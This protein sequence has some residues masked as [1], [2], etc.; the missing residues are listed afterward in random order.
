[1][2]TNALPG[3]D[4]IIVPAG[5]YTIFGD[6]DETDTDAFGDLDITDSVTVSGAGAETTIIEQQCA[7]LAP[8]NPCDRVFEIV[9]DRTTKKVEI[10]GVTIQKGLV[11]P[12]NRSTSCPGPFGAGVCSINADLTLRDCIIRDNFIIAQGRSGG[13]M[14][15]FSS[16]QLTVI[17]CTITHNHGDTYAFSNLD[18]GGIYHVGGDLTVL[19]GII[20]DNV[21][22]R[23]GGIV[24]GSGSL[25]DK[26]TITNST[27][28][29][30]S[31]YFPMVVPVDALF[32]GG[33]AVFG[34]RLIL[35]NS[36]VSGNSAAGYAGGGIFLASGFPAYLNNVTITNNTAGL[37]GGAFVY[38]NTGQ[39]N[40][41]NS[42]L[43]GN[44]DTNGDPDCSGSL[45]SGGY[46]LIQTVSP[47]CAL[48][49]VLTGNRTGV[50]PNL[51]PLAFNGG[52][53]QTHALLP[54][55]PAIDAG[56][57]VGCTDSGDPSADPPIPPALL[58]TDQRSAPR[59]QGTVCDI[60]AYE[61]TMVPPLTVIRPNGGEIWPIGGTQTIQWNP[62]G[63]VGRVRIDLSRDDG[64]TWGT[65]YANTANSGLKNWKVKGPAT[66]QALIRVCELFRVPN[67]CNASDGV[68]TIG[69]GSVTVLSPNGGEAWT[70]GSKRTIQWQADGI[71]GKVRIE[72]S[73]DNGASWGLIGTSIAGAGAKSWKVKGLTTAQ[74][75]IR[76]SSVLDPDAVD[77]SDK[78]FALQ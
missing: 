44:T 32:G 25:Y 26:T 23:G 19:N 5:T 51:G 55:S 3:P 6:Q 54:G 40:V 52:P 67:R 63:V 60:G 47:G 50:S 65:L 2:E 8:I 10:A 68:F 78:T 57:P 35:T 69:G 9:G 76:M 27:I 62:L 53:T 29:N 20:S 41:H 14:G 49:G 18:G 64:A 66:A 28:T 33:L 12:V 38:P 59:P 22:I 13:G 21:A 43:A 15:V 31:L 36:T 30:N 17:N 45:T 48:S 71:I 61:V 24:A 46:N 74:A 37:G 7:E 70:I 73:R 1:M 56:N 39:V 77:T 16:G 4:T 72:L 11:N 34:S 75:L 58:T 42:I